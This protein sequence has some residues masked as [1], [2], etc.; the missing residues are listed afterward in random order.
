MSNVSS[1][2]LKGSEYSITWKQGHE[3]V[4]YENED[5]AKKP[6]EPGVTRMNPEQEM[7]IRGGV[8]KVSKHT[9]VVGSSSGIQI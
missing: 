2:R 1:K 3:M 4:E 8:E 7:I 5:K 9:Q 6:G